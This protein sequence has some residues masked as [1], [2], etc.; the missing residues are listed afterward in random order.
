[1]PLFVVAP[2][3]HLAFPYKN[4][5]GHRLND[6]DNLPYMIPKNDTNFLNIGMVQFS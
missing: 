5:F 6:F 1:M 2:E 3:A 4:C